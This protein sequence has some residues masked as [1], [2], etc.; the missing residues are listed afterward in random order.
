[1][2]QISFSLRELLEQVRK[3][4]LPQA[5]EKNLALHCRVAEAVYDS[6]I[7]DSAR[8]RQVLLN[9][10]GN[11]VKFTPSGLVELCVTPESWDETAGKA[12][13]HFSIRDTGIP[14]NQ[15]TVMF[16]A[17][18]QL[19]DLMGGRWW[20]ESIPSAGSTFH[21]TCLMGI[22]VPPKS[23]EF[24]AELDEP[25]PRL[26]IL[27]A[28]DNVI[29]QHLAAALLAKRNHQVKVVS[30]GLEA[31]QAWEAEIFDVILMDHEMPE[32]SG[33]E[34]VNQIRL[35][36]RERGLTRRTPIVALSA[37]AMIGDRERFLAAGM[38]GYLAKPFR[39]EELY[40][41]L[42]QMTVIGA[43]PVAS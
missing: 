4:V 29:N 5:D 21:F 37:S 12:G 24:P 23:I 18:G 30:T 20:V 16:E 27:L 1:L 14:E 32:M 6:L 25:R 8:L 2:E 43:L 34:A 42:Q 38:D 33:I 11:A 28:E 26:R 36:E 15:V 17:C 7:G 13:L 31:V 22:G 10:L 41:V 3:I 40:E 39:A 9:L 35:L 19:V